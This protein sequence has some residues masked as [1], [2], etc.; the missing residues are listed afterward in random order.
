MSRLVA[1]AL[2]TACLLV[3]G[4]AVALSA[5]VLAS[6]APHVPLAERTA[7]EPLTLTVTHAADATDG[8]CSLEHCTLREAIE[9]ANNRG[10]RPGGPHRI[11]FA[12][13]GPGPHVIAPTAVL[14]EVAAWTEIDGYTQTGSQP[15]TAT[16]P[17]TLMIVSDG[18]ALS[19]DVNAHGIQLAADGA[20]LRGVHVHGFGG[21]AV[22]LVGLGAT[23]TGSHVG[24]V[25]DMGPPGQTPARSQVGVDVSGRD[26]RVGGTTPAERNVISGNETAIRIVD[27]ARSAVIE[28][29]YIG[30]DASGEFTPSRQVQGVLIESARSDS[31][32]LGHRIGGRSKDAGNVISG[33]DYGVLVMMRSTSPD[34][35][36]SPETA[37]IEGNLIGTD[38]DGLLGF[39]VQNR[40]YGVF[41]QRARGVTVHD[42]LISGNDVG[43]ISIAEGGGAHR[44]T[45]NRIGLDGAGGDLGNGRRAETNGYGIRITDAAGIVIGGPRPEDGNVIAYNRAAAVQITGADSTANTVQGNR[46]DASGLTWGR[47]GLGIDLVGGDGAHGVTD[48][49]AADADEGP[50]GL[51]NHPHITEVNRSFP[52]VQPTD[53]DAP[54]SAGGI[55]VEG[56]LDH[57]PN[58]AITVEVFGSSA[59]HLSG[60]GEGRTPMGTVSLDSGPTG[61]APFEVWFPLDEPGLKYFSATATDEGGST[62][63]FSDCYEPI[64]DAC[65]ISGV[66]ALGGSLDGDIAPGE[67]RR[68]RVDVGVAGVL[69]AESPDPLDDLTLDIQAACREAPQV[70]GIGSGSGRQIGA[71]EV[72]TTAIAWAGEYDIIVRGHATDSA[73]LIPYDA[74]VVFT[75]TTNAP[76]LSLIV[77]DQAALAAHSGA[78]AAELGRLVQALGRY[79]SH[80]RVRGARLDLAAAAATD[81]PLAEA[82]DAWLAGDRGA[83]SGQRYAALIR[84]HLWRRPDAHGLHHLVLVGGPDVIPLPAADVAPRDGEI[85]TAWLAET[86]YATALRARGIA[87]DSALAALLE[88]GLSPSDDVYAAPLPDSGPFGASGYALP[89]LAVGRV[90]GSPADMAG[91]LDAFVAEDGRIATGGALVVGSE[92]LSDAA[93][94]AGQTLRSIHPSGDGVPRV[95]DSPWTPDGL[96][97]LWGSAGRLVFMAAHAD[98]TAFF[99]PGADPLAAPEAATSVGT[100]LLRPGPA[101]QLGALYAVACHAGLPVTAA[102]DVARPPSWADA[103]ASANS[104]LIAPL[105]WAYGL[106]EAVGY[107]EALAADALRRAALDPLA[108]LG[109]AL[110]AAKQAYYRQHAHHADVY[111]A[112]TLAGTALIGLPQVAF[113]PAPL[114]AGGAIAHVQGAASR[115]SRVASQSPGGRIATRLGTAVQVPGGGTLITSTRTIHFGR[116]TFHRRARADGRVVWRVARSEAVMANADTW[117]QPYALH[118]EIDTNLN[119]VVITPRGVL[120]AGARFFVPTESAGVPVR[121]ARLGAAWPASPARTA[122]HRAMQAARPHRPVRVVGVSA[123]PDGSNAPWADGQRAE[124][125]VMLTLGQAKP[126]PLG[127]PPDDPRDE[128]VHQRLYT[129]LTTLVFSSDADDVTPPLLALESWGPPE[130]DGSS[131][132]VALTARDPRP[133]RAGAV[134]AGAHGDVLPTGV[135]RVEVACDTA[136]AGVDDDGGWTITPLTRVEPPVGDPVPEGGATRWLAEIPLAA[137]AG[138]APSVADAWRAVGCVAQAVDAAG[139]AAM[140]DIPPGED[141]APAT[142]ATPGTPVATP[143]PPV[144]RLWLPWGER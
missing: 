57:A 22:R 47:T 123:L 97:R 30:T 96:R 58:T 2:R 72:V 19:D 3:A 38:A 130:G 141:P 82:R 75:P 48:N 36:P 99:A 63:E 65:T 8:A 49:D 144:G 69:G 62:S 134:A 138:W 50:N 109:T 74:Q 41:L 83:A 67:S 35:S 59:C 11:V 139:N 92:F 118:R 21:Q 106:H 20:A 91:Q 128:A 73:P 78:A 13:P 111:H 77:T 44:I 31:A 4:P 121:A 133:L 45:A 102:G 103:A 137:A 66:V 25:G 122:A 12:I 129:A 60:H 136:P 131:R 16:A 24:I 108:S 81:P 94:A 95:D 14:P 46:I 93:H 42:N 68:Y 79:A 55:Y 53:A 51:V 28:G 10:S 7:Q 76:P 107:Q 5:S 6:G 116:T 40:R 117:L 126:D 89:R 120:L 29:N 143:S 87:V 113:E 18:S 119:D 100:D 86:R 98:H 115:P 114:G 37:R 43:G 15:A 88:A 23:I 105:G 33:N 27:A 70:G 34:G 52:Q 80:Q 1:I 56:R 124:L 127:P 71:R 54:A 112:K 39:D 135:S 110:V 104:V 32:A 90:L 17:A 140:L 125:P 61:D 84:D 132:S 9:A 142:P 101:G 85:A 26:N 64:Q